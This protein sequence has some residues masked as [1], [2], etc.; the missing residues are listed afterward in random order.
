MTLI[1]NL[2]EQECKERSKKKIG[3]IEKEKL[4]PFL[5]MCKVI[6]QCTII[7]IIFPYS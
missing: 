7:S 6:F 4:S 1:T 2:D 3:E 5:M